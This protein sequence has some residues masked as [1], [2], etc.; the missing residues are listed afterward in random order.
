MRQAHGRSGQE[1]IRQRLSGGGNP[2]EGYVEETNCKD[3]KS[4]EGNDKLF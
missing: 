1:N 3:N 2:K 4:L